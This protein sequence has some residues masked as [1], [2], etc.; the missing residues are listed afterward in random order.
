MNA[1]QYFIV[2]G[3]I[4][5]L[6]GLVGWLRAGSKASFIAGGVSG[7]L[8]VAAGFIA[9]TIGLWMGTIVSA[10]LAGRFLP[11]FLKGRQVYPA[12]ILAI[13]AVVGVVLGLRAVL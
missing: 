8:L 10:A 11:V 13:L 4:S 12:G 1:L 3:V 7:A 5:I 9:G 6:L 2:F